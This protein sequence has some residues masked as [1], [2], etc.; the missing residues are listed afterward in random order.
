MSAT[1]SLI[2]QS[3][4]GSEELQLQLTCPHQFVQ[5]WDILSKRKYMCTQRWSV[6]CGFASRFA[7]YQAVFLSVTHNGGHTGGRTRIACNHFNSIME[8]LLLNHRG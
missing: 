1:V 2:P 8:L 4:R 3:D 6:A 5:L 7:E